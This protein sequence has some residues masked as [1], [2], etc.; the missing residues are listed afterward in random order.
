MAFAQKGDTGQQAFFSRFSDKKD[1]AVNSS[2]ISA[3][4]IITAHLAALSVEASK[5]NINGPLTMGHSS[6]WSK[7]VIPGQ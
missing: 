5:M 1:F 4:S 3:G 2:F 6:E 7:D